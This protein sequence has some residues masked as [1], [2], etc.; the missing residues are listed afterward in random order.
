[1]STALKLSLASTLVVT[2]VSQGPLAL[3]GKKCAGTPVTAVALKKA[4]KSDI[5]D[6]AVSAGSFQT[7]AAA[8]RPFWPDRISHDELVDELDAA[9]R[10]PGTTNAWTMPIKARIDMLSTGVRTPIGIKVFGKDLREIERIALEIEAAVRAVPG[11]RSAF[12][13]RVAG[14]YYLDFVCFSRRLVIEVDGGQ[15]T[16]DEQA[17]HDAV[18]DRVLEG[19]GFRVMRFWASS[20]HREIDD[21][22]DAIVLAL[23]ARALAPPRSRGES[24]SPRG[25]GKL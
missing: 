19:Q 10:I 14:G 12:A 1:M 15:H 25:G 8:L 17:A 21:V 22:M 4:A 16:E 23:E 7:L 18:R 13:E 6:T 24:P 9:L 2:L 3:A 5:V 20:V 11:V